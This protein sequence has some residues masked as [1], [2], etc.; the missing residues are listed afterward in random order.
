MSGSS[1]GGGGGGSISNEEITCENLKFEA[2]VASPNPAVV[3]TLT[4]NEV[5]TVTVAAGSGTQEVQVYTAAGH[6][7]G[8]LL[9]NRVSRLRECILN[10]TSYTAKVIMINGGQVRVFVEHA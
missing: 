7:V 3:S 4:V 5:L 9:A 2:Q 10:G 8:G 6:L 1:G